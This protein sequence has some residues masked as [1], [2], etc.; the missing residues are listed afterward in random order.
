MSKRLFRRRFSSLAH[1]CVLRKGI[2]VLVILGSFP[3][4][5]VFSHWRL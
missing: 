4:H 2:T 1:A 3:A 5:P